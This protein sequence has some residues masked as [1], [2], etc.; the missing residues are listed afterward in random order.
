M[1]RGRRQRT[2][3]RSAVHQESQWHGLRLVHVRLDALLLDERV[4]VVLTREQGSRGQRRRG[5]RRRRRGRRRG[6]RLRQ[7]GTGPEF[8]VGPEQLTLLDRLRQVN[9]EGLRQEDGRKGTG[10]AE[11]AHDDQ[12]QDPRVDGQVHDV[13]ERE[14]TD[15][16]DERGD[17]HRL[18]SQHRRQQ[19]ADEHVEHGERRGDAKLAD[20]RQ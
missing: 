12:R 3:S 2:I 14:Q 1:Q 17:A 5:R 9:V 11:R 16:S 6:H 10:D 7:R 20:H 18:R 15:P 8:E 13:R 4:V 19:L